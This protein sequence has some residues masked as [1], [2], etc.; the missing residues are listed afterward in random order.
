M[1][2]AWVWAALAGLLVFLFVVPS[3]AQS[4]SKVSVTGSEVNHGVVLVEVQRGTKTFELQCNE[5]M[6][7]CKPLAKGVYTMVELPENHGMY[8]CR[9]VEVYTETAESQ[10]P[11][12]ENKQ[13]EYCLTAK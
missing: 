12:K 5:G 11:A 3:V 10:E 1:N 6:S 4:T 13:G 8:V 2:R 9:D 7:A